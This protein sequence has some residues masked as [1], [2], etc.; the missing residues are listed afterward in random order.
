MFDEPQFDD[1][2]HPGFLLD[3][4]ILA[5]LDQHP[6]R[7]I[8]VARLLCREIF[9][10]ALSLRVLPIVARE[11]VDEK[12]LDLNAG[13]EPS[14]AG[15]SAMSKVQVVVVGLGEEVAVLVVRV[16]TQTRVTEAVE[17]V[18]VAAARKH[19][20]VVQDGVCGHREVGSGGE[21]SAV[22]KFDGC[23]DVAMKAHY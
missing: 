6:R 17:D 4:R 8:R 18:W 1:K 19:A 12:H 13:E 21:D 22:V 7:R 2:L 16:F 11:Q 10:P 3:Y 15:A 20:L 5:A 14:W 9:R 23:S